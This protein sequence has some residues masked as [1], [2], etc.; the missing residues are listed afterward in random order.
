MKQW[1][2]PKTVPL[3]GFKIKVEIVTM[4]GNDQAEYVYGDDG[5]VIRIGKDMSVKEQKYYFS[6]ELQ[7]AVADYHHRQIVEGGT[8]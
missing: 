8:P 5:G 3:P 6:H 7:H 4:T 1:R 2:L